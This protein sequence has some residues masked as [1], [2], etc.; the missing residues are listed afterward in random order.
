MAIL[1]CEKMIHHS[2]NT[3]YKQLRKIFTARNQSN[4]WQLMQ[5]M[6]GYQEILSKAK[7]QQYKPSGCHL[8]ERQSRESIPSI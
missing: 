4:L 7:A 2:Q 3:K 8:R 1:L 5:I 6:P